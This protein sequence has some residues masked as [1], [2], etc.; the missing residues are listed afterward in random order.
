MQIKKPR[1]RIEFSQQIQ[2]YPRSVHRTALTQYQ[3]FLGQG[4]YI[5]TSVFW[6]R[7]KACPPP[8]SVPPGGS[9]VA[10]SHNE[11]TRVYPP[12]P[13]TWF[14]CVII[15]SKGWIQKTF[16][17]YNFCGFGVLLNQTSIGRG[18]DVTGCCGSGKDTWQGQRNKIQNLLMSERLAVRP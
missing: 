17:Y 12:T 16:V 13:R 10:V 18:P 8:Q 15:K 11:S 1:Q 9:H 14:F 7:V 4:A 2:W 6:T 3:Q 5:Y